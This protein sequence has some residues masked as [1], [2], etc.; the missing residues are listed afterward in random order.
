MQRKT[1]PI[2]V[3]IYTYGCPFGPVPASEQIVE[4]Q[5]RA[6]H[7][8]YNTLIAIELERR[9][10][11]RDLMGASNVLEPLDAQIAELVEKLNEERTALKQRR[12]ASRKRVT[13]PAATAR[14]TELRG[15]L[16][17][18]RGERK[19]ASLDVR[20]TEDAKEKLAALNAEITVKAKAARA[21]TT[22]YWGTYLLVERAI[23]A[24]RKSKMD[25]RFR[26]WRSAGVVYNSRLNMSG[27]SGR[28]G[29]QLQGG[30]S[31]ERLFSGLDSRARLE[32][33]D[34]EAYKTRSGRRRLT[35]TLLH[36]RVGS[37][38]AR[39]PVWATFQIVLHRPIPADA[40]VKEISIGR[41]L[42]GS[43]W[44]WKAHFMLEAKSFER[45]PKPAGVRCAIDLGWRTRPD[46]L[47]VG[48]L[49]DSR[50]ARRE[51]LL[52]GG[53]IGRVEHATHLRSIRRKSFDLLQAMLLQWLAV[54]EDLPEWLAEA[55]KTLHLWKS[56]GRLTELAWMWARNRFKDDESMY[57]L[58]EQWRRQDLHLA[59]WQGHERGRALGHRQE[60]YRTLAHAIARDYSEIVLE[61]MDLSKLKRL[62][63][64]EEEDKSN[65]T[66]RHNQHH[67]AV[68]ELR[69][70]LVLAALNSGTAIRYEPSMD[71]TTRCH[72]CGCSCKWD[73]AAELEHTCEHCGV[74]WDQDYN[75]AE[76]LLASGG[77]T[78][79]PWAPLANAANA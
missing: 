11:Y 67:A 54:H 9:K 13:D 62:P 32:P 16:A 27:G 24:A 75:A 1:S 68:G 2:P 57:P 6:G 40:I 43:R 12:S 22:C 38:E 26:T 59:Q 19:A 65:A 42:N 46:G 56:E 31:V 23:E 45:A 4:D 21:A 14:M 5:I 64:P 7:Q 73:A 39:A 33:V 37:T 52:P 58:V 55:R 53:I 50:G 3:R 10:G 71:T 63:K 51:L 15:K 47:R 79:D 8:Y 20:A 74:R 17:V 18:I 29:V 28:I 25:P 30:V 70:A 48:Y 49:V 34:A 60:H 72:A 77:A 69:A 76:N 66:V 44:R 78:P 36:V 35:R 41:R 61:K